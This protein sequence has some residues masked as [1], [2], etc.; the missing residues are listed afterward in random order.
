MGMNN[1]LKSFEVFIEVFTA[2]FYHF[3]AQLPFSGVGIAF[4]GIETTK[5]ELYHQKSLVFLTD[6]ITWRAFVFIDSLM[7]VQMAL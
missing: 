6:H 4:L 5:I 2:D 7:P 3:Y 1:F